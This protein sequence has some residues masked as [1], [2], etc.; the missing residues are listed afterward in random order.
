MYARILWPVLL[1]MIAAP[2]AS[3]QATHNGASPLNLLVHADCTTVEV[4]GGPLSFQPVC[5]EL[6]GNCF[7]GPVRYLGA[8]APEKLDWRV[9]W[10]LAVDGYLYDEGA[11]TFEDRN[12]LRHVE[13]LHVVLGAVWQ[14]LVASIQVR[15]HDA[16]AEADWETISEYK[17]GCIA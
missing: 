5:T 12:D 16:T 14:Q 10:W 1:L 11:R 13:S 3:V 8:T 6:W 17:F 7:G 2:F 15:P 4:P 9:T